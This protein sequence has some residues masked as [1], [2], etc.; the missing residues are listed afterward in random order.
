MMLLAGSVY[1][2]YYHKDGLGEWNIWTELIT[3]KE[4]VIAAAANVSVSKYFYRALKSPQ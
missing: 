3:E 4:N 1:D 2:F